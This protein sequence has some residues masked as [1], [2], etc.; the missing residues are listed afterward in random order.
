MT[1]GGHIELY[2]SF[3]KKTNSSATHTHSEDEGWTNLRPIP[4]AKHYLEIQTKATIEN[5]AKIKP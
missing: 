2:Q 3:K 4:R 1:K 5:K